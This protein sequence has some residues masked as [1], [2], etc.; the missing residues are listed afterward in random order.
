M[1]KSIFYYKHILKKIEKK[2]I[3]MRLVLVL[4]LVF[5]YINYI[6][7]NMTD[8]VCYYMQQLSDIVEQR[9]DKI[10]YADMF[11]FL[12][13]QM[14]LFLNIIPEEYNLTH[15][16]YTIFH[17][18]QKIVKIKDM[19]EQEYLTLSESAR[20]WYSLYNQ[21][22]Q[23]IAMRVD[24][25]EKIIEQ[26]ITKYFDMDGTFDNSEKEECVKYLMEE[27]IKLYD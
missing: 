21:L 20:Q 25:D 4:V 16:D 8:L 13:I 1:L 2:C 12:K 26:S 19:N 18:P 23:N 11:V 22:K 3:W 17:D 6:K 9:D 10:K 24:K 5:Q 27:F 14:K 7:Q 15:D